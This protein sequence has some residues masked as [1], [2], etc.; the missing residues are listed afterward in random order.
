MTEV[1]LPGSKSVT[2]RALFL[3]AAASG[4]T[5][6]REP[7]RAADTRAFLAALTA[8]GYPLAAADDRWE[9]TGSPS[10]PPAGGGAVWCHDA[11]TASRFLPALCAAG[12]GTYDIDASAQMRARPMAPLLGA[13]RQLGADITAADGDHLPLR[14]RAAG[15]KGGDVVLDAGVSS[16]FLTALCLL[17]PLTA[18]GLRIRVTDLVS[19]PYVDL[20]LAMMARF[21]ARA[22]RGARTGSDSGIFTFEP[23][24]YQA[25][26]LTIEPD[27]STAS[28][29][30]AAAALT[31]NS[32]TVPGL[33][34]RS[35]Q[36]DLAFGTQVLAAMGAQVQATD[37]AITVTGTGQL[38]GGEFVMRDISD[39]MPT[40]AAIAPFADGPVTITGVGN[41]RVKESD[42]LEAMAVNLRACGIRCETGPDWI[43]VHPGQ[44]HG[45][46]IACYADHRIAMACSLIGLRTPGITLDDPQCVAKTCPDFHRLLAGLR[47]GW[48]LPAS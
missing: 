18:E 13:L 24:G 45:A 26:D 43:T 15:V 36:G 16:Q 33:G 25:A 21:G 42:R 34:R 7:L 20:T 28:Y 39:T 1:R 38:S 5:V 9:I 19:A 10:G 31:G 48:G 2:A 22:R 40:L 41:V 44:P 8:L 4:R 27:A 17:G 46:H 32:V 11:A 37:D 12:H 35:A 47:A 23:T 29:F 6:L 3:A 14:I 30:L